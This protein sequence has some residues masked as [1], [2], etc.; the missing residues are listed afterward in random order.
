MSLSRSG[1]SYER[2]W[3]GLQKNEKKS[4]VYEI[5]G[6]LDVT[7]HGEAEGSLC[8]CGKTKVMFLQKGVN[9]QHI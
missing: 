2:N 6:S 7:G 1:N 5:K 9:L 8:L 3:K 4:Y